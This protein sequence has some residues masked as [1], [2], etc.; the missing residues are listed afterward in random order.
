MTQRIR[1]E[2]LVIL[3]KRSFGTT[4]YLEWGTRRSLDIDHLIADLLDAREKEK[5]L[6][7]DL[8]KKENELYEKKCLL[9]EVAARYPEAGLYIAHSL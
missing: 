1:T 3:D 8:G 6:H 5:Q 9:D 2:E 4:V 7:A